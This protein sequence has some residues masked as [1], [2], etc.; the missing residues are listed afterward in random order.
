MSSLWKIPRPDF[1]IHLLFPTYELQT[2][3]SYLNR[4]CH[5]NL[6][7]SRLA[8]CTA[9]GDCPETGNVS[10]ICRVNNHIIP[11]LVDL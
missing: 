4:C 6:A 3:G 2:L 11:G 9:D 8:V 7:M 10:A 5:S 1:C